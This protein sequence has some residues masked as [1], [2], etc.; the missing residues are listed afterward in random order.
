MSDIEQEVRALSID[1]R[2]TCVHAH[3]LSEQLGVALGEVVNRINEADVRIVHCQLGLFGYRAFGE[4]RFLVPFSEIPERLA[5]SLREASSD[6]KL[7]CAAAWAIAE[8]EGLPRPVVGSA[9][10]ALEIRITPCQLG[11]F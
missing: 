3:R 9:A 1:G 2:L 11:C 8:R 7:P 10:E 6:G 5:A 4:K